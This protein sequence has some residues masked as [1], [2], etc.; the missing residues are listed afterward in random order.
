M[1]SMFPA[2][3]ITFREVFEAAL[4]VAMI[5]GIF[6]K[7]HE[8]QKLKYVWFGVLTAI[9]LSILI[10]FFGSY[11]GL[12]FQNYYTGKNEELIEGVLAIIT[13]IFVTWTVLTLNSHFRGYKL[14]LIEKINTEVKANHMIGIFVLAFT[15]V[16]REGV[17]IIL[18]LSSI[19]LSSKPVDV[20]WGF[21]FGI[22]FG[23]IIS[24]LIFTAAIRFPVHKIFRITTILLVLFS[25]GL[26]S[27]GIHELAEYGIIP[28]IMKLNIP[29]VPVRETV[30]GSFVYGLLGI[31]NVMDI[32][33]V[34]AYMLYAY[35][36]MHMLQVLPKWNIKKSIAEKQ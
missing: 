3:L 5:S 27:K 24:I 26:L 19:L 2:F 6:V 30:I 8:K 23:V 22:F 31:R 18:M 1:R 10:V 16:F 14:R 17:E 29:F 25:A 7:L 9:V 36:M 4:V 35:G 15:S 28:E 11:I 12:V 20:V 34:L 13:S 32:V 33:Q 21:G